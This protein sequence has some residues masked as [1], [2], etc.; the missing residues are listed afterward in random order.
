VGQRGDCSAEHNQCYGCDAA[1]PSEERQ[2]CRPHA[3]DKTKTQFV[4][5][6]LPLN[7]VLLIVMG[8]GTQLRHVCVKSSLEEKLI[9]A[10][11]QVTFV[12]SHHRLPFT[13]HAWRRNPPH[14][15]RSW[16]TIS[17]D[18]VIPGAG[19]RWPDAVRSTVKK[20]MFK[21][22]ENCVNCHPQSR[23]SHEMCWSRFDSETSTF[24]QCTTWRG[25]LSATYAVTLDNQKQ[26]RQNRTLPVGY[27][28]AQI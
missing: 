5:D 11:Q 15:L 20:A 18:P 22:R 2:Q 13:L 16:R 24:G 6:R 17:A 1:H 27:V 25:R 10:I 4:H 3:T 19:R 9:T 26:V 21:A 14:T 8:N 28:H 12:M 7:F 23:T